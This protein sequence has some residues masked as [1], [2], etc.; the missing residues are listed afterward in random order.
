MLKILVA[1]LSDLPL[2]RLAKKQQTAFTGGG[3]Y[4]AIFSRLWTKVHEISGE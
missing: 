4:G 2:R 3:K 1:V